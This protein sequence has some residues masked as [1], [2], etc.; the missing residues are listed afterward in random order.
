MSER[1]WIGPA[2]Q[3]WADFNST[4]FESLEKMAE[5]SAFHFPKKV[6]CAP[7]RVPDLVR[8]LQYSEKLYGEGPTRWWHVGT[9]P[10]GK[11]MENPTWKE[12]EAYFGIK[13][14]QVKIMSLEFIVKRSNEDGTIQE[15]RFS[16]EDLSALWELCS[17]KSRSWET[18]MVLL[19]MFIERAPREK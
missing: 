8:F 19:G 9:W 3:G 2:T 6:Y 14:P 10:E 16:K 11:P 13:I 12:L 5:A 15:S 17:E 18:F 1:V 7:D 4:E